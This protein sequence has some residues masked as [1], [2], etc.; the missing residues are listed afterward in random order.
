MTDIPHQFAG[1]QLFFQ[2]HPSPVPVNYGS[3][4]IKVVL[5]LKYFLVEQDLTFSAA[6]AT[7]R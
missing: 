4:F 1:F 7:L 2:E 5:L 3:V 6:S